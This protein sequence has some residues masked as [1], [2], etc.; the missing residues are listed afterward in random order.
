[1]VC[2]VGAKPKVTS[3]LTELTVKRK[4]HSFLFYWIPAVCLNFLGMTKKIKL[5]LP[6]TIQKPSQGRALPLQFTDQIHSHSSLTPCTVPVRWG[7]WS[8][9]RE[10][11]RLRSTSRVIS[12]SLL[13]LSSLAS[14]ELW[15]HHFNTFP[16]TTSRQWKCNKELRVPSLGCKRRYG[17]STFTSVFQV[18]TSLLW[19]G[20]KHILYQVAFAIHILVIFG[21]VSIWR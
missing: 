8:S 3:H 21:A 1:M 7:W 11:M 18:I 4:W 16:F 5:H 2:F 9:S 10:K 6:V 13:S 19:Q 14:L 20:K 12:C 17:T 15:W